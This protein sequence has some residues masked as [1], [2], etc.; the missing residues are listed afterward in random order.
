M[1]WFAEEQGNSRIESMVAVQRLARVIDTTQYLA[2]I[3]APVLTIYPSHGPITTPE[4]E[5]LLRKHVRNLRLVHLRSQYHNLHLTQAAA[6][7]NHLL[8]FAAQHDGIECR[9]P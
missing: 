9:E 2:R 4:Q 7:A 8:H 3:E 1:N 6:C 5:E